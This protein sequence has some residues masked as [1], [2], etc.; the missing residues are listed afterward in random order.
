M[1][2]FHFHYKHQVCTNSIDV[3]FIIIKTVRLCTILENYIAGQK[4]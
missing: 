4:Y 2:H 1:M 3:V